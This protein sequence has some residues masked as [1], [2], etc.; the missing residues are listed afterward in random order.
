MIRYAHA[1]IQQFFS[2]RPNDPTHQQWIVYHFW[3]HSN[4][5]RHI[6]GS[7]NMVAKR[8]N[9]GYPT[10]VKWN[11]GSFGRGHR[12][13]KPFNKINKCM[14]LTL[15][16]GGKTRDRIWFHLLQEQVMF[17]KKQDELRPLEILIVRRLLEFLHHFL[18]RGL[19][20]NANSYN[21]IACGD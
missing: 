1:Y 2:P 18:Q 15:V 17:V 6:V 13:K 16:F 14:W 20:Q 4:S 21:I 12:M 11:V 8:A 19:Q 3:S 5:I 7:S 9:I 10:L